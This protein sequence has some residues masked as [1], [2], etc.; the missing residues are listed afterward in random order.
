MKTYIVVLLTG[1][2][3]STTFLSQSQPESPELKEATE[4]TE[5]TTKLLNEGKADEA[6]SLAKRAL[7]IRE[8]LL[9]P[10]DLKISISL[11][12]LGTAYARKGDYGSAAQT[13]DRLLKILESRFGAEDVNLLPT[14]NRLAMLY[15]LNDNERKA[16]EMFQRVLVIR[17]K[18][19]GVDSVEVAQT[20]YDLGQLYRQRGD[21]ARALSNYKRSLLN[22][23]RLSGMDTPDFERVS[24]GFYCLRH[25]SEKKEP[26]EELIEIRRQLDPRRAMI[27]NLENLE[28]RAIKVVQPEYPPEAKERRLSGMVYLWIELDDEGNVVSATDMCQAPPYLSEAAVKAALK[29]RFRG[30]KI[31]VAGV[32]V[33]IKGIMSYRFSLR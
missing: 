1:L 14:L 32:P 28:S 2:L 11:N 5:R 3:F 24:K 26:L 25:Q 21:F 16:E 4:L 12:Y 27:L 7:Q 33:K 17:E 20:S 23:G 10:T 15:N 22:Y 6:V 9:P 18:V 19:F 13:L 31:T 8:K 29:C 30:G